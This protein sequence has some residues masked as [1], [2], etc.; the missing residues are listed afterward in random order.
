[1][2]FWTCGP[3]KKANDRLEMMVFK[4]EQMRLFMETIEES[5]KLDD[6]IENGTPDEKLLASMIKFDIDKKLETL[7]G[8]HDG[9]EKKNDEIPREAVFESLK[10]L[11]KN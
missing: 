7:I 4:A 5:T 6:L 11:T 3:F 10:R 8:V 2:K 9:Y 1:M